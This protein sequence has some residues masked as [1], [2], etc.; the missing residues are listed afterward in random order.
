MRTNSH[1]LLVL[2]LA[3]SACSPPDSDVAT[4]R[5]AD[6]LVRHGV[7]VERLT[8]TVGTDGSV[9]GIE[10]VVLSEGDLAYEPV[11]RLACTAEIESG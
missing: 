4:E 2:L 1:R 11:V 9:E 8:V 10:A 6:C 3:V 5:F 7:E